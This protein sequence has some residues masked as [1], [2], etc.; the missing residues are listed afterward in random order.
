MI[1]MTSTEVSKSSKEEY[2]EAQ[3]QLPLNHNQNLYK[4][5]FLNQTRYP[6]EQ[7]CN[8]NHGT[9]C[10]ELSTFKR[11]R[12]LL[13]D[14]ELKPHGYEG[15]EGE[16]ENKTIGIGTIGNYSLTLPLIYLSH[17]ILTKLEKVWF[18]GTKCIM[19]EYYD[20]PKATKNL[21]L[22]QEFLWN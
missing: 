1:L 3:K 16:Q 10:T 6:R 15:Y 22:R 21:T 8:I 12:H 7:G 19:L 5:K 11:K 9:W 14:L 4:N 20:F 13:Q 2:E 18:Q 17:F